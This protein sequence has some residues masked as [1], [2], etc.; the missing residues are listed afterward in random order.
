MI[1]Q[2]PILV[3]S[4]NQEQINAG[5]RQLLLCVSAVAGALGYEHVAGNASA[6]LAASGTIA[7]VVAFVW[8]QI[9]TRIK[10]NRSVAMAQQLPNSVA[11]TK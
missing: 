10:A 6:L 11:Q 4:A 7:G 8:G 2:Q 3:N 1:D 5:I 9:A